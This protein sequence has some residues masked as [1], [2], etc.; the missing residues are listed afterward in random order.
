MRK[1]TK[2]VKKLLALFLVVLMSID[3]FA[4]IVSDNDGSAFV[5][6][7]EFEAMKSDFAGQIDGYNESIDGKINGAIAAYL[8]GLKLNT[9]TEENQ[10][11]YTNEGILSPRD[12]YQDLNFKMGVLDWDINWYVISMRGNGKATITGK[13]EL[14]K[15]INLVNWQSIK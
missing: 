11:C 6:K 4:A 14:G 13:S 12:A 7:A 5:T 15:I 9:I 1:S 10:L 3:S 8:A 2:M